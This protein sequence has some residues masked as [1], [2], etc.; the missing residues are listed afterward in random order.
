MNLSDFDRQ[1]RRARCCRIWIGEAPDRAGVLARTANHFFA[2]E[3]IPRSALPNASRLGKADLHL[4]AHDLNRRTFPMDPLEKGPSVAGNSATNDA[5]AAASA[6]DALLDFLVRYT[7]QLNCIAARMIAR[8]GVDEAAIDAPGA[9]DLAYVRVRASLARNKHHSRGDDRKLLKLLRCALRSVIIDECRESE[10]LRR[11][12]AGRLAAESGSP[13]AAAS[14]VVAQAGHGWRQV[15][16]DLDAVVSDEPSPEDLV[17]AADDFQ[18][19]YDRLPDEAHRTVLVM[20]SQKY[21]IQQVAASLGVDRKTVARKITFI[22]K[23]F[24]RPK[25]K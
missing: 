20:L 3:R 25:F 9:V 2:G 6:H 8:L 18:A 17:A 16:A 10:C 22:K 5:L 13:P 4:A 1:G 7:G 14:S 19:V 15:D 24:E 11:G 23:C 12:G 21:T